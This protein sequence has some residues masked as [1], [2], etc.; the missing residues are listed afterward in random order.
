M[1]LKRSYSSHH[2]KVKHHEETVTC[3]PIQSSAGE[4]TR[5]Q[6]IPMNI[7]I[8]EATRECIKLMLHLE[9]TQVPKG[10]LVLTE[11]SE[12]VV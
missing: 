2:A 7:K 11:I 4:P 5:S 8:W 9:G 12:R 3:Q 10:Y 1:H 6:K